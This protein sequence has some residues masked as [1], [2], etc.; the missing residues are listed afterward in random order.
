MQQIQTAAALKKCDGDDGWGG[1]GVVV[2]RA[3]QDDELGE[4]LRETFAG[5]ED[6]T[7][8]L[9]EATKQMWV[10]TATLDRRTQTR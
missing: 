5:K 7:N 1:A 3:G 4:L 8:H 10:V 6:P 9:P 2:R